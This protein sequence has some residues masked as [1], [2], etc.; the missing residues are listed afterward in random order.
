MGLTHR[1]TA[2]GTIS[3]S[4]SA[5][6]AQAKSALPVQVCVHHSS[7]KT[8]TKCSTHRARSCRASMEPIVLSIV[9]L[10]LVTELCQMLA[11]STSTK[12]A[13][14][15]DIRRQSSLA[16]K[17]SHVSSSQPSVDVDHDHHHHHPHKGQDFYYLNNYNQVGYLPPIPESPDDDDVDEEGRP[18]SCLAST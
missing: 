4:F 8:I 9:C 14:A 1:V 15:Y 13:L 5:V 7:H 16:K 2:R 11:S 3:W 6:V 10:F 17:R 12:A 18:L